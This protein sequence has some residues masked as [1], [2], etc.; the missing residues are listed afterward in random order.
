M[1]SPKYATG[2][3]DEAVQAS[4]H[5]RSHFLQYPHY[6]ILLFMPK[7]S[8]VVFS[9]LVIRLK[10]YI[11]ILLISIEKLQR[12]ITA[13]ETLCCFHQSG[14]VTGNTVG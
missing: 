10:F 3:Y 7:V 13:A 8:Q 2:P 12:D 14:D 9:L 5:L 11:A 6:C 1:R 4:L